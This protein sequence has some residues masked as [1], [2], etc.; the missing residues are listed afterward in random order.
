MNIPIV[1]FAYNRPEVL[2]ETLFALKNNIGIADHTLIFF[3]DGP[4]ANAGTADLQK[5]NQVRSLIQDIN[6]SKAVIVNVKDKNEGLANSIVKGITEV[7]NEYDAI[8]VLEDDIK[9]SPFFLRYMVDALN[10]YKKEE[11]VI[12]ISG[13][14]YPIQSSSAEETFFIRGADCWGWATWKRGWKLFEN[15][16]QLLFDALVESDLLYD[17]NFSG[18]YKYSTML[19]KTIKVNHSWAVKWYASAYLN[20]KLTLYPRDSLVENIG[21]GTNGTNTKNENPLVFSGIKINA[22]IINFEKQIKED[23]TMRRA[24]ADHMRKF[25]NIRF[26]ILNYCSNVFRKWAMI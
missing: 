23:K 3:C 17:F 24:M 2:K 13:Y 1:V 11:D 6:W 5:I 22:P 8:I 12:S 26:R 4:K 19:K 16:G 21:A 18:S 14:N 20:N 7:L 15:D 25:T 10:I 9:T